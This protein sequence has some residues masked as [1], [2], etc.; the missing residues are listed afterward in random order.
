MNNC[1]TKILQD[2][3]CNL[4]ILKNEVNTSDILNNRL[5]RVL[6]TDGDAT[7]L[8]NSES[9]ILIK[10]RQSC[11]KSLI[12]A[13]QIVNPIIRSPISSSNGHI[14]IERLSVY[15]RPTSNINLF[16]LV[17]FGWVSD[18]DLI[19]RGAA[20][21]NLL[22]EQHR[23]LFNS[24]FWESDRFERFCRQPSSMSG[25]HSEPS[26]NLRHTIEVAEE[27][28][29]LCLVRNYANLH[30]GLLAA[31]LHDAGKSDEYKPNF[32]GGWDLT[33][34]GKLLGH[35][36]TAIEWIVSA[37]TRW[38]IELPRDHYEGL[39]HI[40]SAIPFAPEWM[41]LRAPMTPESLLLSMADRLSGHDSLMSQ[42]ISP[43][44]GFGRFH[45]H[46]N[47]A[48]FKVRG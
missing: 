47:V 32:K 46:L 14:N 12:K 1:T 39:L 9:T 19:R 36:V 44:G 40:L 34:R 29:K 15:S 43:N 38:N 45:K 23:L 37:V 13:G 33:D 8:F 18:R 22:P 25:H 41:G 11:K 35:K 2:V 20:L 30:L 21:V 10:Q 3:K 7:L 48:P 6:E 28:Q 4:S 17:P 42:T 26:G 27:M 5:F 31:F 16:N 24:I